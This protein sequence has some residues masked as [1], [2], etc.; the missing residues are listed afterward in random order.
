MNV[1][2]QAHQLAK[3][4]QESE[5]FKHFKSAESQLKT[6]PELESMMNDFQAKSVE[7]QLKQMSGE[8]P[9]AEDLQKIQQLYGIVAMDPLAASYME[10]EMRFSIM[11]KDVYEIIGEAIGKESLF[12]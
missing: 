4:I 7:I 8:Q 3:A 2:D 12:K 9:D 11:M 5:E 1:Y 6:K 10:S